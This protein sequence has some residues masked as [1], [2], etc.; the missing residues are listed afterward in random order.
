[1]TS[2]PTKHGNIGI[3][4]TVPDSKLHLSIPAVSVGNVTTTPQTMI[5]MGWKEGN[6]NLGLGEGK[7]LGFSASLVGDGTDYLVAM[8]ASFK[9]SGAE[10]DRH[11]SLIFETSTNGAAAPTEKMRISSAGKV[12]IGNTTPQAK[13]HVSGDMAQNNTNTLKAI[14]SAGTL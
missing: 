8:I 14:N 11:S 6:Q 7:A 3:G 13:L 2:S 5:N 4:T 9:E 10:I 12:G 1:M